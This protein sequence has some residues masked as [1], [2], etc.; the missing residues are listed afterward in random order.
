MSLRK[1]KAQHHFSGTLPQMQNSNLTGCTREDQAKV[2][3]IKQLSE[4]AK[5]LFQTVE[6]KDIEY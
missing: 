5:E 1:G 6:T 2:L 4:M 3:S